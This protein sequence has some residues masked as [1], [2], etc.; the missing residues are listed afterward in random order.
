M[1]TNVSDQ[2]SPMAQP[3]TD[4]ISLDGSHSE[5]LHPSA[6]QKLNANDADRMRMILS[7]Q[8]IHYPAMH[9]VVTEA[10][11]MI[12]EPR[13]TRARGLIICADRGNGK[14]SLAEMIH[15]RF[16]TYNRSDMP[17]VLKISMSGVRDSRAVYGRIMEEL[18][19]PARISHRLSDREILVQRLL[20]DVNCRLLILDEVQDIVLGSEREQTRA[21]EGIKMLM[22]ELRLPILAFGTEKAGHGFRSDSHLA[23]RFTEFAMP[24]WKPDQT[25]ADFLATYERMLPLKKPSGLASFD[26]VKLLAKVGEGVLGKIVAR[27]RNAAL[28]AIVDGSECVTCELLT[29]AVSRPSICIIGPN[30]MGGK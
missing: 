12:H 6:Y 7:D 25:L 18:G 8:V 9:S 23:A 24:S 4:V 16:R 19:S 15:K 1:R 21:L 22:N 5:R 3:V 10:D 28:A 17:C 13:Q 2:V 30:G 11:W 20:K 26:S 27:V 29:K 14:T